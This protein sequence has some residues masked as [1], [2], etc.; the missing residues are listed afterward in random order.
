MPVTPEAPMDASVAAADAGKPPVLTGPITGPGKPYTAALVDL[1]AAGYVEEEYFVEGDA[2]AYDWKTPP[3]DDGAW[4]VKTTTTAHYKTRFL[5]RRPNDPAHFNG[6]VLVEWLNVSGGVDADPDFGYAHVELLRSGWAYVG[7]SA[8]AEGVVGGGF[9]LASGG[10]PL[11]QSNPQRY[12][13]LQH[14][15]DNY[16]YDIYSQ[17]ARLVRHPG[18]GASPLGSLTPARFIATGESQS[19][20]RMVTYANA[21]QPIAKV[22]DGIFI[23]SRFA[24]AAAISASG[25]AGLNPLGG[26]PQ[27]AH[28]RG[29]LGVPVFQFLTETDVGGGLV[30]AGFS[31]ARQP[32]TDR[33]RSWEVAGTSHADQY[34]LDYDAPIAGDAGLTS[35][36]TSINRGPQH[37]VD[38]A[39]IHALH[40][41]VKDGTPPAHGDPLTLADGGSGLATDAVGNALGGIRT[42]AVDVP[43]AVNSGQPASSGVLCAL[44]GTYAPL[45]TAQLSSLYPTHDDYVSKVMTATSKAQQAGFIV[46]AD[47]P[48]IV[49]EADAAPVPQ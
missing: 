18:A 49:Q 17:V 32:D 21:I 25:G 13:S 40:A 4:S 34:L 36:C 29:D 24:G 27:L 37:W 10:E 5:V 8:Q 45:S 16:C 33:L 31:A 42:A 7:I 23:H 3:G 43:I 39:A 35:S 26:G 14:P 46:S 1:A 9:A 38:G 30:G 11:V 19:A 2:T 12:G 28:I 22:F 48:L 44:F 6:S 47:T 15:G 41:W 20:V